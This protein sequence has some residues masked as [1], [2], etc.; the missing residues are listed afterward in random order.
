[1]IVVQIQGM[2]NDASEAVEEEAEEVHLGYDSE[3]VMEGRAVIR[4]PESDGG[5]GEDV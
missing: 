5:P 2:Q 3:V 4:V 1:M